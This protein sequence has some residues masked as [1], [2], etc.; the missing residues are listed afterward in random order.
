MSRIPEEGLSCK[1]ARHDHCI[2]ALTHYNA[3]VRAITE[4]MSREKPDYINRE[5][6]LI[7]TVLFT[8]ISVL[9][10]TLHEIMLHTRSSLHMFYQWKFLDEDSKGRGNRQGTL[11]T[12]KTALIRLLSRLEAQ[13]MWR[14]CL[15][16]WNDPDY[17]RLPSKTPYRSTMDAYVEMQ[18]LISAMTGFSR[19]ELQNTGA[20]DGFSVLQDSHGL[21]RKAVTKWRAKYQKLR[22]SQQSHEVDIAQDV[23]VRIWLIWFEKA[24]GLCTTKNWS[25]KTALNPIYEEVLDLGE[26]TADLMAAT[27]QSQQDQVNGGLSYGPSIC[28]PLALVAIHRDPSFSRRAIA[29][30]R[31]LGRNEGLWDTR[32][33][34]SLAEARML[35]E[36]NIDECEDSLQIKKRPCGFG[37]HGCMCGRVVQISIEFMEGRTAR[38]ALGALDDILPGYV[39]DISW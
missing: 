8:S 5:I 11:L 14:G 17:V 7:C 29:L 32:F 37:Q 18:P 35:V 28:E 39:R 26:K 34:A 12:N 13:I 15:R 30:L 10:G 23:V 27:D 20:E 36:E 31:R 4:I 21:H 16:D 38:L 9:R 33:M 1:Q 19:S 25:C 6:F 2:F 24:L 22:K 3:A